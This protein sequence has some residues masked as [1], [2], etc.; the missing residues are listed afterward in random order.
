MIKLYTVTEAQQTIL[1]R[2][3]ALEPTIPAGLQASLDRLF[4][5]GATPDDAVRHILRDVRQQGDAA[6]RTWTEKI[7]GVPM[8]GL[9]VDKEEIT[10]ALSRIPAELVQALETAVT[11]IRA[12]HEKQPLPNWTTTELGG[13]LGQR[14]TPIARVGAYVP[15]GTAPLPSSLLMSVIPAQVAGVPDIVVATPPGKNGRVNDAILAAAAICGIDT[16]NTLG[17]A[18]AVAALA[19]GTESVRRV[20]KIVGA[21]GLFTTLAKR[22]VY[23]IVGIDGLYGPTE[24]VVVADE[25][26]NP[27]WVAADML[28]QAEHDVLATAVLFTPSRQ[29]AEAVQVEIAHQLEALSRAEI[30][31]Q[32]L[33][34]QGG[35][36]LTTDMDEACQLASD[37]AA[38]HTC[39]ATANPTAYIGKIPNAGGLFVG[40]RSFEVLGDYVAGPSHVMPTSGT[41]R[42]ASPLNVMDF[43]KI[44]SIVQLDDATSAELSAIA[45]TIAQAEHLTAHAN[46]AKKRI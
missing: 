16:I 41:A 42:F 35:I 26:A 3:M 29:F 45:A 39:I 21:G 13:I 4:G 25:T 11:R 36:V 9:Q 30:I 1:R 12:F 28:A 37:F 20:D 17:G 46:A 31:A 43:V 7:D 8:T 22:Q 27:A 34:G 18:Q 23:G 14:V 19:F 15:G 40:E 38:E 32:S 10:A 5:S 6:L 33:N 44:S 2:E 24:T